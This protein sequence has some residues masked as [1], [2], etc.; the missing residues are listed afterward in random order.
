MTKISTIWIE[1]S[2]FGL[3]FPCFFLKWWHDSALHDHSAILPGIAR[4]HQVAPIRQHKRLQHTPLLRML[5]GRTRRWQDRLG[6]TMSSLLTL[7]WARSE[8]LRETTCCTPSM[9]GIR[10][11]RIF[12]SSPPTLH[13][14]ILMQCGITNPWRWC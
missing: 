8:S 4:D 11:Q 6:I 12:Q 1:I 14:G 13:V 9:Q 10:Y 7:G 3:C 2:G 5:D